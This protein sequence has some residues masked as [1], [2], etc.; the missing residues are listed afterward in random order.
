MTIRGGANLQSGIVVGNLPENV[1]NL[2]NERSLLPNDV[3]QAFVAAWAYDLPVG[4]GHRLG[5][6]NPF[7][8]ALLGGWTASATQRYQ[9]GTPLQIYT[10]NNN[11]LLSN[12]VQ[13]PNI[14][15]GQNLQTGIGIGS[16]NPATDRR[17]TPD[18]FSAPLPFTFDNAAPTYWS[19][20]NFPVLQEDVALTTHLAGR[21]VE[22]RTIRAILQCRQPASIHGVGHRLFERFIRK[23]GRLQ[24]RP[25]CA[26][27]R[28]NSILTA[29][30]D[31]SRIGV[32]K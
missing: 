25:V 20:R 17:I 11:L 3:P 16:F 2:R 14:V 26:V 8:R 29:V 24:R 1:Y 30:A 19:L 28:E 10:S 15:A 13:R 31:D 21:Q 9:A 5:G 18:A 12:T 7:A 32:S 27:G 4:S 22:A 23:A 6:R